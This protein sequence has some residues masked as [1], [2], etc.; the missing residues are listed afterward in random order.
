[1]NGIIFS[2]W[3]GKIVDNRGLTP[4]KYTKVDN[5][6]L[7]LEYNDY[8]IKAFISWDGLILADDTV[9]IVDMAHSYVKEALKVCCGECTAGYLGFRVVADILARIIK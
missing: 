6:E 5:I 7:P 2:S 1:M 3:Q 9:S 4:E 8:K